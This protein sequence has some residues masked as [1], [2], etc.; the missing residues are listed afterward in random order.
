MLK[1]AV[2]AKMKEY[3][4]KPSLK[5]KREKPSDTIQ[6]TTE[7]TMA[8]LDVIF[9]LYLT[10]DVTETYRSAA[11]AASVKTDAVPRMK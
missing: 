6:M 9:V 11:S 2:L 10:G 7:V 1:T 4:K 5:Y 3:K 8:R